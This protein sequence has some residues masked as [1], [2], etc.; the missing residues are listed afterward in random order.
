MEQA[1]QMGLTILV[2]NPENHIDDILRPV[3]DKQFI[4]IGNRLKIRFN[5]V[6]IE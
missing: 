4:K 5:K 3:I 1:L 6:E 2:K